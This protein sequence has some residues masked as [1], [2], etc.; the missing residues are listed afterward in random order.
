MVTNSIYSYKNNLF[1]PFTDKQEDIEP[2]YK[3]KNKS[4]GYKFDL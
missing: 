4:N 1:L 3:N 2:L